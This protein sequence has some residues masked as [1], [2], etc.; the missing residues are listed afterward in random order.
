LVRFGYHS[1]TVTKPN[2]SR[3]PP[4][5]LKTLEAWIATGRYLDDDNEV[6]AFCQAIVMN[7]L[8]A[9]VAHADE[10][11]IA[12]LPAIMLWLQHHA[13]RGSYGSP[14]ALTAWPKLARMHAGRKV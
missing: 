8:A 6:D 4:N 14:A 10:A 12:A 7:D 1:G 11:N 2:F 3:I 9:A 13:P 5:T